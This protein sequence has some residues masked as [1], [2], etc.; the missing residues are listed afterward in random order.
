MQHLGHSQ[1]CWFGPH[2]VDELSLSLTHTYGVSGG[3]VV[4]V[5][6]V[7]SSGCT[8]NSHGAHMYPPPKH[9]TWQ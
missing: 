1:G 2:D 9:D 3:V 7:Q 8:Q 5:V 6:V 4:V